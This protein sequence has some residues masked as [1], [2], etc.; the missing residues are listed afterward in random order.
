MSIELQ[1]NQPLTHW[2]SIVEAGSDLGMRIFL[3]VFRFFGETACRSIA[4]PIAIYYYCRRSIAREAS[5][6][7]LT[8]LY[9]FDASAL[10]SPPRIRDGIRHF[11]HFVNAII[12]K[13][14]VWSKPPQ[15]GELDIQNPDVLNEFVSNP[16]GKLIIGSHFGNLEY[17]RGFTR[18]EEQIV[19][20][21]LIH[22]RHAARF[23]QF[24]HKINPQTGFN[25]YQVTE[26]DV[27][28]VL[29][30]Q[31]AIARGEIVVIAGDR[32]PVADNVRTTS[33]NFL[34]RIT[35]MPI[36]PYILASTLGCPVYLLFAYRLN[37]RLVVSFEKFSDR[38]VISRQQRDVTL[39]RY[40]QAF[41][42]RLEHHCR[43]A[44]FEWFN[45]YP[46]WQTRNTS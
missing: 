38:I 15:E 20:N 39:N 41:M 43:K 1:K 29:R 14:A 7:Y 23:A 34:G 21:V 26:I 13:A 2:A 45:F 16:G 30:L 37:R 5:R 33:V 22:D 19:L 46:F 27:D 8:Q 35:E 4:W 6:E 42:D 32:I 17:C 24:M 11:I 10:S 18:R 28:M 44:P 3:L 31:E 40:A 25:L 36:G 12:D 9:H